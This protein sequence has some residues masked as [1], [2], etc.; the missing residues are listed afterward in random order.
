V[1]TELARRPVGA[2][3]RAH[4]EELLAEEARVGTLQLRAVVAQRLDLAA[5]QHQPG[6]EALEDVVVVKGPPVLRDVPLAGLFRHP[7]ALC[8]PATSARP[9]RVRLCSSTYTTLCSCT[10]AASSA[11]QV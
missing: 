7:V 10:R 8:G 1:V 9:S 2:D 6:L 4:Q 11:S 3:V 5:G